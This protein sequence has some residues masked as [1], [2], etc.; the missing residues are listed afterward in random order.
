RRV[1]GAA[2]Q[3]NEAIDVRVGGERL[4][5]GRP[6]HATQIEAALLRLRARGD[7]DDAHAA[8]TARGERPAL[9]FDQA[10][11]FSTNGAQARNPH[12]EWRDH[13][14]PNLLESR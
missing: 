9:A 12:L 10:N 7:G 14:A 2:D 11:D 4:R 3:F 8:T 1:A 13:L 5:R 6:R